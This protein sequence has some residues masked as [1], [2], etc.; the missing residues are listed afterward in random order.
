MTPAV[1]RFVEV[2]VG[3]PVPG[4]YTYAVPAALAA[5]A[6]VGTR[7][8]VPFGTRGVEG[9]I[10]AEAGPPPAGVDALPLAEV[11]DTQPTLDAALIRLLRFIADYYQAPP[12]EAVRLG[13]PP[14]MRGAELRRVRLT[15]RGEQALAAAGAALTRQGFELSPREAELCRRLARGPA[16]LRALRRE[17]PEHG[18]AAAALVA[19]GLCEEWIAPRPR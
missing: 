19:R 13:M 12:G 8:R 7:V 5:A 3:L 10:V 9:V 1:V 17:R 11:L 6:A 16:S 15:A 14:G 2:A 18:P 4:T